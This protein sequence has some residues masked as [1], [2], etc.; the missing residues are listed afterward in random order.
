ML[1]QK[2]YSNYLIDASFQEVNSLFVLLFENDEIRTRHTR[3]FLPTVEIKDYNVM[4]HGKTFWS[5]NKWWHKIK[6]KY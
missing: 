3:Y 4:I 6:R 1:A 2:R 5:F